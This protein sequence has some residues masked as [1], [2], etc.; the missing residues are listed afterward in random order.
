M[1]FSRNFCE[2]RRKLDDANDNAG[3]SAE[4]EHFEESGGELLE[5]EEERIRQVNEMQEEVELEEEQGELEMEGEQG[6]LEMEEEQ[7][8]EEEQEAQEEQE[9]QEEGNDEDWEDVDDDSDDINDEVDFSK[10][11][12]KQ[13][14]AYM[15]R[16][17]ARFFFACSLSFRAIENKYC[18]KFFRDLNRCPYSWTPPSRHRLGGRT[19]KQIH[20]R[21]WKKRKKFSKRQIASY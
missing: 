14:R 16:S 6:E 13:A 5:H 4:T 20:R 15:D 18:K 10:M 7:E 11:S 9:G 1:E 17:A 2:K 21:I 8:E 3:N 12:A 19:L